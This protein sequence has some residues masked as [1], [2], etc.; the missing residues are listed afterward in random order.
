MAVV[1]AAALAGAS[2][3]FAG[4]T[5]ALSTSQVAVAGGTIVYISGGTG[6]ASTQGIRFIPSTVVSCPANYNTAQADSVD[7]GLI[8]A[9]STAL[10]YVSTPALPAGTYKPCIYADATTGAAFATDTFITTGGNFTVTAVPFATLGATTGQPADKV[11]LTTPT[12]SLTGTTYATQFVAGT[13]CPA[14]YT[15]ASTTNI[16]AV[17]VKTSTSVLT[18]TVP[19]TVVAG[20]AYSICSYN[21]TTAG[22]STLQVRGSTTFA[23]Y[24]KTLPVTTLSPNNGASTTATTVIATVPTAAASF[25]G[26]PDAIV[27]RWS[28]PLTRPA[29]SAL[30]AAPN[31]EPYSATMN[32]ISTTRAAITIPVSVMVGGMD[33]STPWNVC[34]YASNST[35]AALL[36]APAVYSVAPAVDLTNL[37]F[38]VGSSNPATT[39]SGPAQGNSSVTFSGLTGIPTTVGSVL[40]ASLGSSPITITKVNSSSSFTGTTSAHAA[41]AVNLSITTA[42]GTKTT[43]AKP[44]TYTYGI[45][46]T[47]NTAPAGTNNTYLD[48]TG[49]GFSALTWGATPT[50][51]N[52]LTPGS[53]YIFLTGNAWNNQTFA[54]GTAAFNATAAPVA[55]CKTPLP[56]S[57]TEVICTLDLANTLTAATNNVTITAA[58]VPQ[59]AY[60]V[61]VVNDGGT[62]ALL[63]TSYNFSTV[64]STATFTVGPY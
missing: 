30:N 55:L 45:T 63:A 54:T 31:V 15:A 58:N 3:A 14:T 43:S 19:T 4:A 24:D 34:I 7:G 60:T 57:D 26:T 33:T 18:V 50:T 2:P 38:A 53:A 17:T 5:L 6:L 32:R 64:A 52:P 12:A 59:G 42:A 51:G 16:V 49:A 44:Y 61:T 10:A 9:A 1:S 47:P 36:T 56:I 8:T 41:G 21:G 22:T 48:I 11:T 35:G 23:S 37:K 13:V 40:S 62:T 28:C 39:G 20:T 25:T 46:V 27:S 29:T